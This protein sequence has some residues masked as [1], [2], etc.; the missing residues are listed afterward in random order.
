MVT[1]DSEPAWDSLKHIELILMLEEQFGVQFSEK[2][3]AALRS[4]DKIVN[5]I[6]GKNA[7]IALALHVALP[8]A[9]R[10]PR[11]RFFHCGISVWI[12]RLNRFVHEI[13]PRVEDQLAG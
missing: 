1:R 2:E 4:S 12:L 3:M 10:Y 5:A 6:E 11:R 9:P 7:S 8:P 13:S